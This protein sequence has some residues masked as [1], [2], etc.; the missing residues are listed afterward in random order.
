MKMAKPFGK[1][2]LV[3]R[4]EALPEI[5]AFFKGKAGGM[6]VRPLYSKKGQEAKRIIVAVQK[7][8]KA[9]CRILPPFVV[10]GGDGEYTPAA[11]KILR[12]GLGFADFK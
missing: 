1:I 10:H 7:D 2:Y 3:N 5:C 9:P 12:Q 4:V 8:S 11:Q 6:L